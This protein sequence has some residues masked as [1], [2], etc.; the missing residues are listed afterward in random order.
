MQAL[1]PHRIHVLRY[2]DNLVD[3]ACM[4]LSVYPDENSWTKLE[5]KESV[6]GYA[7]RHYETHFV[8]LRRDQEITGN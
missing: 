2:S 6:G 1:E 7:S 8:R 4:T 5:M 3:I